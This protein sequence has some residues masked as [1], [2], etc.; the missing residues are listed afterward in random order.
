MTFDDSFGESADAGDRTVVH[1]V[2]VAHHVVAIH[3]TAP[4]EELDRHA[5]TIAAVVA[6][7]RF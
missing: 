2:G 1:V 6:S 7:I 3:A 4:P 5:E